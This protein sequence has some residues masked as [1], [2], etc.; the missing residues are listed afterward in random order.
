MPFIKRS[1]SDI[2]IV[3]ICEKCKKPESLCE[4]RK[5]SSVKG[6][7]NGVHKKS[8]DNRDLLHRKSN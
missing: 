2:E 4:C 5:D 6:Q 1:I 7:K 3:K 8:D